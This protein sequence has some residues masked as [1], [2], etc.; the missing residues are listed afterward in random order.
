MGL[1]P[2]GQGELIRDMLIRLP[3]SNAETYYI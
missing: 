1:G 3:Y 2:W